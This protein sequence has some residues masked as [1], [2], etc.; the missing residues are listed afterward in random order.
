MKHRQSLEYFMNPFCLLK[1]NMNPPRSSVRLH[2]VSVSILH[3]LFLHSLCFLWAHLPPFLLSSE[4]FCRLRLGQ[5]WP[6]RHF[7]TAKNWTHGDLSSVRC[8]R[9]KSWLPF[10]HSDEAF[11]FSDNC[12]KNCGF[13]INITIMISIRANHA[14]PLWSCMLIWALMNLIFVRFLLP[15]LWLHWSS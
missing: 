6:T 10:S 11:F 14:A 4:P 1:D 13:T 3:A 2:K 7:I 5:F 9:M 8:Y 15:A 12:L